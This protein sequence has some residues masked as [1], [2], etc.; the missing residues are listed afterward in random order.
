MDPKLLGVKLPH[1]LLSEPCIDGLLVHGIQGSSFFGAMAEMARGLVDIEVGQLSE[2]TEAFLPPLL[3][4]NRELGK[5][6]VMSGFFGREDNL[7]KRLQDGGIPY[8]DAPERA[9]SA[10]AAL[11]RVARLR[12]RRATGTS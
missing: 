10:M 12:A 8:F 9:V 3:E 5:P 4:M 7:V 1:M 11:H 2:F 6:I